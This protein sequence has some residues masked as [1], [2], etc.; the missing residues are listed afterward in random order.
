MQPKWL[1]IA[2]CTTMRSRLLSHVA[3]A[4]RFPTSAWIGLAG[5]TRMAGYCTTSGAGNYCNLTPSHVI[6]LPYPNPRP[7]T[8]RPVWI[9]RGGAGGPGAVP[10]FG[11]SVYALHPFFYGQDYGG[12]IRE[13]SVTRWNIKG[14][15]SRS[16]SLHNFCGRMEILEHYYRQLGRRY[17]EKFVS[18]FVLIS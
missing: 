13:R 7:A 17:W 8:A 10:G 1:H 6:C 16:C 3:V 14:G 2:R 12:L 15:Y 4:M 9:I 18:C 5:P 11:G